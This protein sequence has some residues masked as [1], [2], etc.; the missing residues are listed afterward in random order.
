MNLILVEREISQAFQS[1]A[2]RHPN[3]EQGFVDY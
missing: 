3:T 1:H 2:Q